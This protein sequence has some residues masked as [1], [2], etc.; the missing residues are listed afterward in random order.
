M[1]VISNLLRN[2]LFVRVMGY[3][4]SHVHTGYFIKKY[5]NVSIIF[6]AGFLKEV[7]HL[8][9]RLYREIPYKRNWLIHWLPVITA[10]WNYWYLSSVLLFVFLISSLTNFCEAKFIMNASSLVR[11]LSIVHYY[12]LK[13]HYLHVL[14]L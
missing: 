12:T 3:T 14:N 9:W 8:W 10:I 1:E 4:F 6:P 11:Y 7:V 2:I 5:M 13:L